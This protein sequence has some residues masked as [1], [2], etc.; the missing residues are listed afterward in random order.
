MKNIE[1]AKEVIEFLKNNRLNFIDEQTIRDYFIIKVLQII[2]KNDI[3][4]AEGF[5]YLFEHSNLSKEW[6][7]FF[8][9]LYQLLEVKFI[10]FGL[11]VQELKSWEMNFNMRIRK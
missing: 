11:D 1:E 10:Y 2:D 3:E 8:L 7:D 5:S 4:E 6:Q 9:T